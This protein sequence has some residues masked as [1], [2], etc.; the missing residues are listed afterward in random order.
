MRMHIW[1]V[2]WTILWEVCLTQMPTTLTLSTHVLSLYKR[3]MLWEISATPSALFQITHSWKTIPHLI[4]FI[5]HIWDHMSSKPYMGIIYGF[6]II[7]G[8]GF[9][10]I[11]RP[12][13][14]IYG[15]LYDHWAKPH[16]EPYMIL[17]QIIFQHAVKSY[18]KS[19]MISKPYMVLIQ[20]IYDWN[21]IIYGSP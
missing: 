3:Y 8:Q 12:F 5:D 4:G 1:M 6:Q 18:V 15:C 19:Y 2:S 7:C 13:S 20:I 11:Y 14:T 10:I 21:Q 16:M 9:Q 17:K